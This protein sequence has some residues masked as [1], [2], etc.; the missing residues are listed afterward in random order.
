MELHIHDTLVSSLPGPKPSQ[1]CP[2]QDTRSPNICHWLIDQVGDSLAGWRS[3]AFETWRQGVCIWT[4]TFANYLFRKISLCLLISTSS[5]VKWDSR[6]Q[7]HFSRESQESKENVHWKILCT[8]K[9]WMDAGCSF[10]CHR[11]HV[12]GSFGQC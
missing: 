2:V 6:Y 4:P 9:C 10:H 12:C 3:G 5:F 8:L 1:R 7:L 11:C